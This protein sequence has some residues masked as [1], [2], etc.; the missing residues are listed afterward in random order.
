MG[1]SHY[2]PCSVSHTSDLQTQTDRTVNTSIFCSI[3]F[4]I[5]KQKYMKTYFIPCR[6][7]IPFLKTSV[8]LLLFFYEHKMLVCSSWPFRW[9]IPVR[10]RVMMSAVEEVWLSLLLYSRTVVCQLSAVYG[11]WGTW[12]VAR[13]PT[14]EFTSEPSV[15]TSA[16]T[17]VSP[18]PMWG[19]HK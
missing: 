8:V 14:D 4:Y 7:L 6:S 18:E 19:Y 10:R 3:Q 11:T 1:L 9:G 15:N 13:A 17:W 16:C 2:Y 5:L 12:T